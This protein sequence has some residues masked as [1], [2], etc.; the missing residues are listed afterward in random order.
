M[1]EDTAL[2]L[3]YMASHTEDMQQICIDLVLFLDCAIQRTPFLAA[4]AKI[5]Y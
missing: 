3:P 5:R 1:P 4:S 2:L